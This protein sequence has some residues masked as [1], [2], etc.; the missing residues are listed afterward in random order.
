MTYMVTFVRPPEARYIIAVPAPDALEAMRLGA[1][2]LLASLQGD[3][4]ALS[5]WAWRST[6]LS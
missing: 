6:E 1:V 2:R 5:E 4:E 3:H